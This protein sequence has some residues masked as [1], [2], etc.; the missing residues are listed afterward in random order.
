[1]PG[2]PG[3]RLVV[4]ADDLVSCRHDDWLPDR[5]P[6]SRRLALLQ[7]LALM[8]HGV[9]SKAALRRTG[10]E[11]GDLQV[12]YSPYCDALL[13]WRGVPQVITCHDLTPLFYPN[14]RRA[15]LR[16][17]LWM[18]LHLNKASAVIAISRFVAD[19]LVDFGVPASKIEVIPNGIEIERQPILAPASN[20]LIMLARHDLN[21]NVPFVVKAFARIL[22]LKPHWE[23]RLVIVGKH[24]RETPALRR[25]I[26][27]LPKPETVLLINGLDAIQIVRL[28]RGSL[29]LISASR[30][31]GF[32]YPALEA[33]AEGLPTLLSD[34]PVHRE[35]Y[36]ESSEFF[37]AENDPCCLADCIIK[38]ASDR[39]YW[40]KLSIAGHKI[41][42]RLSLKS[43][44]S[45]IFQFL[46]NL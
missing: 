43:Q 26:E 36:N 42:K 10:L 16:Y 24:G 45:S 7:Q 41:S 15:A 18:P 46:R 37:R 8:Q 4:D 34:I 20:D 9:D 1:M 13:P 21:K 27:Q 33:N 39:L 23:G 17:R 35:F 14:S 11:L 19:Q 32:D 25:L 44:Q 40:S 38:L 3:L 22:E 30:M 29:A 12:V 28:L 5:P 2:L 6:T 31:E